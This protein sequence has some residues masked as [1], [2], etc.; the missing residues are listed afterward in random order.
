MSLCAVVWLLLCDV[1]CGVFVVVLFWV[2][3]VCCVL[4]FGCLLFVAGCCLVGVAL[5][6]F[7]L[8]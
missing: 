8:V 2:A 6:L 7:L 1:F 3:N 4:L 5:L